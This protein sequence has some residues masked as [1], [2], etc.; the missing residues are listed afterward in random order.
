MG[1]VVHHLVRS[2]P[3]GHDS[4]GT[5]RVH[6]NG[7][8]GDHR[9]AQTVGGVPLR[10]TKRFSLT[11]VAALAFGLVSAPSVFA[12]GDDDNY[13][14]MTAALYPNYQDN[15]A[16]GPVTLFAQVHTRDEDNSPP[17]HIP[18]EKI[19]VHFDDEIV[20]N[21][22]GLA[23]CSNTDPGAPGGSDD[24][25]L[26]G[27]TT[28][29]ALQKCSAAQIG[30][31]AAKFR[32]PTGL[33]PPAPTFVR[34]DVTVTTFNGPTSVTGQAEDPDNEFDGGQPTIILHAKP[35]IG[36]PGAGNPPN[37]VVGELTTSDTVWGGSTG[38]HG[39]MLD[40]QDAPDIA[41]DLGALTLFN[42][43]IQRTFKVK[44]GDRKVKRFLVS[45]TCS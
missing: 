23:K 40:V 35:N 39:K 33:T 45:A 29:E 36:G 28:Q 42:S 19:A 10:R 18:S 6:L 24:Q 21:T 2:N 12:D 30:A 13:S 4:A 7:V 8:H 20:F 17:I 5:N 37:V 16:R 32:A 3:V 41:G 11:G 38:V 34:G 9:G 44:K 27:T 25:E 15:E 26:S 22:T 43:M 1:R 14:E 31:G